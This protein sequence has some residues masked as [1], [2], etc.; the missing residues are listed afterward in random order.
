M[1]YNSIGEQLIAKAQ[2]LDPNYKPDKFNDMSEAIDV[3]LNNSGGG[4]QS[5]EDLPVVELTSETTTITDETVKAKILE[6]VN[7]DNYLI[8]KLKMGSIEILITRDSKVVLDDTFENT[9]FTQ[10]VFIN[11]G[12]VAPTFVFTLLINSK[13]GT[14]AIEY[15]TLGYVKDNKV[16]LVQKTN[17]SFGVTTDYGDTNLINGLEFYF[18]TI[19]G[20]PI[21]HSDNTVNNYNIPTKY[22]KIDDYVTITSSTSGTISQDGLRLISEKLVENKIYEGVSFQG[23]EFAFYQYLLSDS[24]IFYGIADSAQMKLDVD[25][26]TGDYTATPVTDIQI[27]TFGIY[28]PPTPKNVT[29]KLYFVGLN[30]GELQWVQY[31]ADDTLS[32]RV[33]NLEGRVSSLENEVSQYSGSISSLESRVSS[34]ET[35]STSYAQASDVST[36]DSRINDLEN[37]II[38]DIPPLPSDANT[39]TYTLKSVNGVLTWS[40]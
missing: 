35:A 20:K 3:I 8:C 19:N 26:A 40:E 31:T 6:N 22:L 29:S 4:G 10:S 37:T 11:L 27:G 21:I 5:I 7:N 15:E 17:E 25:M 39:K 33:D 13:D 12:I 36:L 30:N 32:N 1:K 2:E 28:L 24:C 18:D 38:K 9:V 14:I 34:L 16:S 23:L